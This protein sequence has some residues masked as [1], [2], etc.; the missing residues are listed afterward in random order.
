ML[1][2]MGLRILL[3]TCKCCGRGYVRQNSPAGA[4]FLAAAGENSVPVLR[5]HEG[6]VIAFARKNGLSECRPCQAERIV[7]VG[8]YGEAVSKRYAGL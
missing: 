5:E 3:I 8:R 4:C 2:F 7:A 1:S 6:K